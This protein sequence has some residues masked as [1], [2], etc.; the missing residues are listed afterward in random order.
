[1]QSNKK[2]IYVD[3]DDVL[4]NFKDAYQKALLT[5]P[6]IIFPQSQPGFFENL[7]PIENSLQAVNFLNSIKKFSVYILTAP[8]VR[9]PLCYT[10]KRLWIEKHFNIDMARKLII[11]PN[12][13]LSKGD[14]LIDDHESG[15]GQEFFEGKLLHFGS[16]KY[17]NW[18]GVIQFFKNKYNL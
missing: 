12:K 13:G 9:N 1:M 4:C 18:N 15:K 3:M 7:K 11:S 17:S 6:E 5:R 16:D 14:Y 10:E 8:S 2:I